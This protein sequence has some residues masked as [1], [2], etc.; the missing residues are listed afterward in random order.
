MSGA[1]CDVSAP[2]WELIDCFCGGGVFSYGARASGMHITHA[3][4]FCPEA[5]DVYKQNFPEAKVSCATL[6]S[7]VAEYMFPE[8]RPKL[9]VHLSPPC[10]ELSNAKSGKRCEAD[11]LEMLRWSVHVGAGYASFSIETVHTSSTLALAKEVSTADPEHI[12][13]G[14]Y[15][16][17]NFSAPQ[18]RVRL[19]IST[20]SIIKQ[21]NEAP[22]SARISVENAFC[23]EGVQLP[24][25]ATHI[26]NSTPISS[27]AN[28]R[29]IQAASFTCCASRALSFCNA[30]GET[31]LSMKPTHTRV[32]MGLPSTFEMNGK[33]RVLQRVLGN[34]VVFGLARAIALAAMGQPIHPLAPLTPASVT[35][36]CHTNKLVRSREEGCFCDELE[37]RVQ[38]LEMRLARL[39]KKK[40][41]S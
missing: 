18:S 3:V 6:G 31:V 15:D 10:Q 37:A 7:E 4:D 8:P 36:R 25:G 32:L 41:S 12:A 23:A 13:Y 40:R 2:C 22:A 5:L 38:R 11:G 33:Q 29:P 27:R 1:A 39:K 19:V 28:I 14:I 16:G 20:P 26:K 9:H 17:I 35:P 24:L 34:G 30:D 21:L